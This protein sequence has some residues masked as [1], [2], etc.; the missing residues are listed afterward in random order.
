M[1]V[2]HIWL[3]VIY[4]KQANSQIEGHSPTARIRRSSPHE[5]DGQA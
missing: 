3:A 1:T 4:A 2:S 5:V